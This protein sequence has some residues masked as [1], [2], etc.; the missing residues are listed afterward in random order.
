[1]VDPEQIDTAKAV[2]LDRLRQVYP[3]DVE[4][5]MVEDARTAGAGWGEIEE[6][7]NALPRRKL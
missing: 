5:Q 1:M 2:A 7:I 3:E 4:Q 6:A